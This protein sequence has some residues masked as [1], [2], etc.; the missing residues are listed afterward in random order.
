MYFTDIERGIDGFDDETVFQAARRGGVRIVGACGG[1]G[2][3]GSCMVR[4][5]ADGDGKPASERWQRACQMKVSA[6]CRIE[7]APRSL[8]TVVRADVERSGGEVLRVDPTVTAQDIVVPPASLTDPAGD[9]ERLLRAFPI[10]TTGIDLYAARQLPR[11]LR[12]HNWAVSARVRGERIIGFGAPGSPLLGLAV[13]LGTTNAAAFL[14]DLETGAQLAG[15][16][17]ENPQA[18]WGAD[19]ISRINHAAQ[20]ISAADELRVAILGGLNALAHDLCHAIGADQNNIVDAAICGNTAMHH[21]LAGLPVEQLGRAPFVSA[22]SGV[23]DVDAL[24]LGLKIAPGAQAH[25]VANIGG[26]VGGDHVAALLATEDRWASGTSFVMDI[27]TNTEMSLIHDGRIFSTSA[28]SGPALEGGHISCGMR[29]AEGAIEKV[30]HSGGHI[31]TQFIGRGPA[32]GL[33]GSGVLDAVAALLDAGI[34]DAGGRIKAGHP[35]IVE[36]EGKRCVQ[37]APGVYFTQHDI[38]AVQLAKAAIRTATELLLRHAG[39]QHSDIEHFV[40]AGAF[41]HYI[42]VESGIAIGLFPSLPRQKFIQVGNAAGLG[43]RRILLSRGDR[44][45]ASDLAA[46]CKYVELSGAPDFQRHFINN[47]GLNAGSPQ[48]RTMS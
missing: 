42:D 27:G 8:A 7:I 17:I 32:V 12:R 28:P 6:N 47:I 30:S 44:Q 35:D 19:V 3:C 21:L 5:A 26:F 23:L 39:L 9:A 37:L 41:G 48:E 33:C 46:R 24:A 43:V 38:R 13:D 29:A 16:G 1:R 15:V 45:W 25:L 36:I 2:T 11:L 22:H 14:L 10:P 20:G 4:I 31:T 34:V 18:P 40:I